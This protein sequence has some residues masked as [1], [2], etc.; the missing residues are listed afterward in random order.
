M[1]FFIPTQKYRCLMAPYIL[2]KSLCPPWLCAVISM[3]STNDLGMMMGLNSLPVSS[4]TLL[5]RMLSLMRYI[6]RGK[7]PTCRCCKMLF[8]L[9]SLACSDLIDLDF[10]GRVRST[11][12]KSVSRSGLIST[13]STMISPTSIWGSSLKNNNQTQYLVV[14]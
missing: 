1:S 6:F 9:A 2:G 14:Q 13:H 3:W 10:K 7:S 12:L 4:T 8:I 11:S 5:L